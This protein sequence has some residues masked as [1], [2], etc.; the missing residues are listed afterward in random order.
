MM[1][2]V[3]RTVEN[4]SYEQWQPSR[5]AAPQD[6]L[7]VDFADGSHT[8]VPNGGWH[9]A[10]SALALMAFLG[11]T[12][13]TLDEAEGKAIP[14]RVAPDGE[15]MI[16]QQIMNMGRGQLLRSDWFERGERG[17]PASEPTE[18]GGSL[19]A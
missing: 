4:L 15:I 8:R 17:P 13:S 11:V 19:G 16:P 14:I 6:S 12:P 18:R 1:W 5:D 10:N 2:A 7:R 9:E 3:A